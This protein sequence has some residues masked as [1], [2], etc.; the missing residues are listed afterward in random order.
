[1]ADDQG[2]GDTGYNGNEAMIKALNEWIQS[3]KNSDNG[4]DY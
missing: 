1:M 2:W 4:Q 3:C